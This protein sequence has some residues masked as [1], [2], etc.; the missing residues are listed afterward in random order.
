MIFLNGKRLRELRKSKCL[1]MKELGQHFNLAESTIS[2]YENNKRSP[3]NETIVKFARFFDVTTDYLMGVTD[4]PNTIV[5]NNQNVNI[6]MGVNSVMAWIN[7]QF[8]SEDER[9]QLLLYFDE[10]L[11]RC[12]RVI[13][14][15]AD[16]KIS[17]FTNKKNQI[18]YNNKSPNPKSLEK[19]KEIYFREH[20]EKDM[21]S[22][23][24]WSRVLP[25]Y[26]GKTKDSD[27]ESS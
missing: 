4:N 26:I 5:V 17:W 11:I 15:A 21:E 8:F 7:N 16:T 24:G 9:K 1:T 27:N 20:L 2:L 23:A 22:L 13:N 18:E 12:K 10:L 6:E 14:S 25:L 3:D 19:L